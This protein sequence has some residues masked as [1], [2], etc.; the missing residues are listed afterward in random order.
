MAFGHLLAALDLWNSGT[1]EIAVVG[2][3]PDLVRAVAER[4]RPNTVLAWGEP[5]PSPL[6]D[7]RDAGPDGGGRPTSAATSPASARSP[8]PD[9]L[10]AQLDDDR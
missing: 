2:D 3:R 10:A 4:Y 6:W 8:T 5:Y 9:D 1:T 7:D